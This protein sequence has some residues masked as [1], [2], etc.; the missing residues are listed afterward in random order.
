MFIGVLYIIW[1]FNMC[2]CQGTR[3]VGDKIKLNAIEQ[4]NL[5]N[6]D[7]RSEKKS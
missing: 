6:E 1:T 5:K 4:W 3:W 7:C 2:Q